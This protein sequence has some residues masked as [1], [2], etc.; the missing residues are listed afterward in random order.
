MLGLDRL[1]SRL[2]RRPV[3]RLVEETLA[4]REAN[5]TPP[6]YSY[7]LHGDPAR[8]RI[9][10]TA[11]VND[12]L[13]NVSGGSVTIEQYAFFGHQVAMLTGSHDVR[14]FGRERQTT[15]VPSGRDIVVQEGVWIASHSVVVGPAVVGAHSVVAAGS[16]VVGDV[17]PFTIVAGRPAKLLR[18]IEDRPAW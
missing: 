10:P 8:L 4:A 12:A 17:E 13:F 7:R 2:L 3:S 6:S 5:G 9:H 11:I 15:L 16:L 14:K 1:F 18:R